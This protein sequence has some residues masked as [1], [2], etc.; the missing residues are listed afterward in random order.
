SRGDV[1]PLAEH[2]EAHCEPIER[3]LAILLGPAELD[4]RCK[5]AMRAALRKLEPFRDFAERHLA[6]AFREELDDAEAAFRGH[7]RHYA[8]SPSEERDQRIGLTGEHLAAVDVTASVMHRVAN[9]RR[10]LRGH[11]D[12]A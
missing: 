10:R 12:V 9:D 8:L 1:E 4:E 11:D 5:E 7:M 2:R 3:R 6:R